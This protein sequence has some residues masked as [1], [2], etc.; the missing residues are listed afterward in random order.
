VH[1]AVGD[2]ERRLLDEHGGLARVI[3]HA[4]PANPVH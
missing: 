2:L 3:G 1:R 4:E